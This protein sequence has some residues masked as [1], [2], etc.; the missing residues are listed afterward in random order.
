MLSSAPR[1]AG[2]S[3]A[4]LTRFAPPPPPPPRILHATRRKLPRRSEAQLL[5]EYVA[6]LTRGEAAPVNVEAGCQPGSQL[7]CPDRAVL[8]E[9]ALAPTPPSA[10]HHL[11]RHA[12]CS[13]EPHFRN[14]SP[15]AQIATPI[16]ANPRLVSGTHG[17]PPVPS[18]TER[19][20][21]QAANIAATEADFAHLITSRVYGPPRPH[22]TGDVDG[23]SPNGRHSA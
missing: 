19:L 15:P 3:P 18:A 5:A 4:P 9:S 1:F 7:D 8:G 21:R 22:T 20:A 16:E 12:H 17:E 14:P 23:S 11:G 13:F 6:R 2:G 10:A